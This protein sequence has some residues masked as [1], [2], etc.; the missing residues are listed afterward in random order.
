M[1]YCRFG[2]SD[3]YIFMS[4][5]GFECCGCVMATRT[6]RE[7]PYTDVL[8][9]THHFKYEP[10]GPFTTAQEMLDHIKEHRKEGHYIPLDVDADIK[11]DYPDLNKSVVETEEER[12]VRIK[13]EEPIRERVRAKLRQHAKESGLI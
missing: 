13:E 7:T 4:Y 2:D 1:S 11:R 5:S 3:A 10:V 9:I 6:A 8:G 12:Q